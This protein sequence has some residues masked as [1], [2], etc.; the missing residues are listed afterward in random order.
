M[1][2]FV[3]LALCVAISGCTTEAN[4]CFYSIHTPN[5]EG[6]GG[7][8]YD[9][10]AVAEISKR[11]QGHSGETIKDHYRLNNDFYVAATC[12]RV[13]EVLSGINNLIIIEISE[14]Q[15]TSLIDQ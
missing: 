13:L 3:A 9:E 8:L 14:E 5:W 4:L 11:I 10:A 12:G 2:G 15:Y 1:K 6:I 7:E